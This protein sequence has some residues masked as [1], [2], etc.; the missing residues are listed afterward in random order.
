[1]TGRRVKLGWTVGCVACV[2]AGSASAGTSD[3]DPFSPYR[4]LASAPAGRQLVAI[5]RAAMDAY[6]DERPSPR[7]ADDPDWPGPPVGVFVSLV[8]EKR[9]RACMGSVEPLGGSLAETVRTLAAQALYSDRRHPP[10]RRE[11]LEELRIVLSFC[12]PATPIGDPMRVDPAREGLLVSTE[13][14]SVAFLP[15]E[16]RTVS[17]ALGEARRA[18]ILRRDARGARFDRFSVVVL[19]EVSPGA[20]LRR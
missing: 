10:V 1:M 7:A 3:P 19:D 6:F 18:G 14:G 9:T 16:A 12:G 17:W 4:Q 2:L 5:A 20:F 8:S 11:E 13:R 15:G